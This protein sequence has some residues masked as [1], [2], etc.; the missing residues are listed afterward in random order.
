MPQLRAMRSG[1]LWTN[2]H[3]LFSPSLPHPSLQDEDTFCGPTAGTPLCTP[4]PVGIVK[5]DNEERYLV[6]V[7]VQV[8]YPTYRTVTRYT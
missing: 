4:L 2:N 3:P 1:F 7:L 6:L 5:H 8:D